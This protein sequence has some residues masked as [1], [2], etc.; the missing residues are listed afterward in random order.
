MILYFTGTGNSRY[1][2]RQLA[3]LTGDELVDVNRYT[4]EGKSAVFTEPGTYVFVC[5]VYVSAPVLPFLDFIRESSF[6]DDVRAYF[7]MCCTSYMGASPVFCRNLAQG[8]GFVY[9]G[10]AMVNMPQNYLIY[11]KTFGDEENREKIRNARPAIERIAGAIRAGVELPACKLAPGEYASTVLILKPFYKFF[12]KADAFRTTDACI[13]CGR[14]AA[15][16]PMANVALREGRPVWGG[17]CIHCMGCISLCPK[18]A[19]EYG[20]RTLGKLRYPGPE[21]LGATLEKEC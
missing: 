15:V 18:Q 7:V 16:C 2:A 20:N 14:C 4:R 1:V 5:P 12:M 21:K 13:G 6:P 17:N 8:K 3:E 9:L 19:I 10:T 11:W